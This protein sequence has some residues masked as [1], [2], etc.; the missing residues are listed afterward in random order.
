MAMGSTCSSL[1][2]FVIMHASC[3]CMSDK[4]PEQV[5]MLSE[6]HASNA[7]TQS[8]FSISPRVF[9][10]ALCWAF[11]KSWSKLKLFRSKLSMTSG[12]APQLWAKLLR[13]CGASSRKLLRQLRMFGGARWHNMRLQ[14]GMSE[15]LFRQSRCG[16]KLPWLALG[17]LTLPC[18]VLP[19][20]AL[21]CPAL[22]C[23][24]LLSPALSC[25][26]IALPWFALSRSCPA[27]P[28]LPC[29]LQICPAW[30][31]S[32][33]LCLCSTG[34]SA[35]KLRCQQSVPYKT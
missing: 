6:N 32:C 4:A 15:K 23:P 30:L 25:F 7:C 26:E 31:V 10:Q 16:L 18:P 27:H 29:H 8:L 13:A 9:R 21:L 19:C 28:D 35:L 22:L 1:K 17:Q 5:A 34:V 11:R 20:P 14:S 12:I 2:L 33:N 3:H 24:D